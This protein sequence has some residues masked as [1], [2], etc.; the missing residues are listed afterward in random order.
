MSEDTERARKQEFLQAEIIAKNFNV[1]AFT[2]FCEEKRS[3]DIDQWTLEE[4][5]ECVGEFKSIQQFLPQNIHHREEVKSPEPQQSEVYQIPAMKAIQN[6]LSQ[7]EVST[8]LE[9]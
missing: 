3:A 9:K 4:L 2:A 8:T 7:V 5:M 1:D 6:E